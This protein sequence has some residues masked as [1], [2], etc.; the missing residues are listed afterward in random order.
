MK[1]MKPFFALFLTLLVLAACANGYSGPP[2]DSF[3]ERSHGHP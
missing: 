2:D 1:R 3:S